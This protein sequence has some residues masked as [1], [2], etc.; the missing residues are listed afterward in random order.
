MFFLFS[1]SLDSALA[2]CPSVSNHM[3]FPFGCSFI[4]RSRVFLADLEDRGEIIVKVFEPMRLRNSL[5]LNQ[6]EHD[7]DENLPV[8]V[9]HFSGDTYGKISYFTMV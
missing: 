5:C 7:Q 8:N 1:F 9:F 6:E 4:Q 3:I 2:T